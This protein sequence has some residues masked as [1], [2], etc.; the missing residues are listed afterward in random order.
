[1]GA[2]TLDAVAVLS[3]SN[4]AVSAL[5]T[6]SLIRRTSRSVT[7]LSVAPKPSRSKDW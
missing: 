3:S 2:A 1:M 7:L 4:V 6:G 5:A